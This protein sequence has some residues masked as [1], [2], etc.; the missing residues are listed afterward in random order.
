MNE[1]KLGNIVRDV[2]TGF[3]GTAFN[4]TE[5]LNGNV[6]YNIQPKGEN[7]SYPDCISVDFHTLEFVEEGC[8]DKVPKQSKDLDIPLGSEV[9][10]ITSG[11]KGVVTLKTF[12]LNG[13]IS[14]LVNIKE[15]MIK[16][17]AEAWVD[18]HKL[19]VI[20]KG[21]TQTYNKPEK[22]SDGVTTGG[23]S[24]RNMFGKRA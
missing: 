21:I 8:A 24:V 7:N 15:T 3:T 23:A 17:A 5:F 6:Q 1:F 4:K 20:G 22:N 14:Y 19:K 12:Y 13:C 11:I 9:E 18:Q 16:P 2:I 10:D